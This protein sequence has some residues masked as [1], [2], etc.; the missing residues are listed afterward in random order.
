MGPI[1]GEAAIHLQE[2]SAVVSV[3]MAPGLFGGSR[4]RIWGY[5]VGVAT[6]FERV[7]EGVCRCDA[8]MWLRGN[9]CTVQLLA[10]ARQPV[11]LVHH[12]AGW[13]LHCTAL[14]RA[15]GP[16]QPTPCQRCTLVRKVVSCMQTAGQEVMPRQCD[17]AGCLL[18]DQ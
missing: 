2:A 4:L 7:T 13:R 18:S 3:P 5:L 1:A 15:I 10:L 9:N 16:R 6:C 11:G 14:P 17:R 12:H 8:G